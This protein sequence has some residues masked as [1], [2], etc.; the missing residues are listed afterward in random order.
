MFGVMF[1]ETVGICSQ[2]LIFGFSLGR[3]FV[4]INFGEI[5]LV[6]GGPVGWWL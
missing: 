2:L 4:Y 5:K 1:K 6:N 3:L